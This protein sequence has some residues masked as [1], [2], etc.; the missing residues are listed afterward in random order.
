MA[1]IHSNT[2]GH[3][4][5]NIRKNTVNSDRISHKM[6]LKEHFLTFTPGR[7]P[8]SAPAV[9]KPDKRR[10]ARPQRPYGTARR[11]VSRRRTGHTGLRRGPSGPAKRPLPPTACATATWPREARQL[12]GSK[13]CLPNTPCG[14]NPQRRRR[15]RPAA[16]RPHLTAP[17]P[18]LRAA[19]SAAR[20]RAAG[21]AT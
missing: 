9:T 15:A 8:L 19:G 11:P 13:I 16:P 5:A 6:P 1:P 2:P 20:G 14:T 4:I 21:L 17:G 3:P 18:R 10:R 7:G 12:P